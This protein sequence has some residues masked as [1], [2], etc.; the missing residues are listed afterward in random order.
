VK[1]GRGSGAPVD[2][3]LCAV[4]DGVELAMTDHGVEPFDVTCSPD[5]DIAMPIDARDAGGLGLHLIRQM[6]DKFEYEY[7]PQNRDSRITVRFSMPGLTGRR[8]SSSQGG[9]HAVD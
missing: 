1:Y 3:R 9:N 4:A 7:D 6:A 2:I 5:V 8:Q